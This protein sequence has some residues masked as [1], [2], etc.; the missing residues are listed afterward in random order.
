MDTKILAID[1]VALDEQDTN[2][3]APLTVRRLTT[4]PIPP[5]FLQQNVLGRVKVQVTLRDGR[6][7][8]TAPAVQL[9]LVERRS[10]GPFPWNL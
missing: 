9:L 1:P 7:L 10:A 4:L 8:H 5:Q 2:H 3:V 6:D